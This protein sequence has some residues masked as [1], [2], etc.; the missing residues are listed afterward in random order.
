MGTSGWGWTT[1]LPFLL[2][3]SLGLG[4]PC[5]PFTL[6]TLGGMPNG[7]LRRLSHFWHQPACYSFPS[8]P[9]TE[10]TRQPWVKRLELA[11]PSLLPCRPLLP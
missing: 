10:S 5:F 4:L 7:D 8:L 6:R 2:E 9:S 11:D 1:K 3:P